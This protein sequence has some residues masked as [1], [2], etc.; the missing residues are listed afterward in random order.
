[1]KAAIRYEFGPPE[2]LKLEEIPTPVPED[3]ELLIRVHAASVTLGDWEL[4]TGRP[5]HLTVI[6]TL[7]TRRPRHHVP[8]SG[9][10]KPK[11][12]ILGTDVAGRV[13]AVGKSVTQFRPG[14]EVFGDCGLTGFGAFA[15]YVCVPER[16]ALAPKPTGMS[17]EQAAAIPQAGFIAVQALRDSARVGPGHKVLINGAGGGAGTLALQIAKTLGAEV[18]AV[19]GP[20]KLEMLLSIGADHVIDYT[21]EDFTKNGRRYDVILDMAACRTV[22]ESRRSLTPNGLYLMAGGGSWTALW[23]SAFLGPLISMRGNGRVRLLAAASRRND[24]TYITE[25][26]EAGKV[27]PVIDKCFPLREAGE[28]LRRVGDKQSKGKVIITP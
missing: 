8:P 24:L 16:A 18:T 22:F 1:M 9:F 23:Q 12:K 25:L 7:F 15:E 11:F 5:L 14:D 19:D 6:A 21:R 13:E 2:V 28:A 3:D 20:T 4:L 27:V 26:F 17:F 10:F